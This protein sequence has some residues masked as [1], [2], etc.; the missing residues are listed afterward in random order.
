MLRPEDGHG[1]G[2][3]YSPWVLRRAG[4]QYPVFSLASHQSRAGW[5]K[6]SPC[7]PRPPELMILVLFRGGK[8]GAR[9]D[10]TEL[11]VVCVS[12]SLYVLGEEWVPHLG[13]MRLEEGDGLEGLVPSLRRGEGG[14]AE[15]LGWEL[16]RWSRNLSGHWWWQRKKKV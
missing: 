15:G 10:W 14:R 7:S 3:P 2:A 1:Q 4:T 9:Q 8:D 5:R 11:A 13:E 16:G 6:G 12:T